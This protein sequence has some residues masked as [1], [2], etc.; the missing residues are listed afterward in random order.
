MLARAKGTTISGL[1]DA[2]I[3]RSKAVKVRLLM[4]AESPDG[5]NSATNLRLMVR[6]MVH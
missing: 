6:E 1:V 4:P 2:K 5:W 3:V